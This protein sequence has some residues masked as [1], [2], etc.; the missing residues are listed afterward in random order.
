MTTDLLM[1]L[2]ENELPLGWV[3]AN[4]VEWTGAGME[5][6]SARTIPLDIAIEGTATKW[7]LGHLWG[8]I[9]PPVPFEVGSRCDINLTV[10]LKTFAAR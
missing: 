7:V 2:D 9:D 5:I 10:N 6:R 3:P 8:P 4:I 1:V